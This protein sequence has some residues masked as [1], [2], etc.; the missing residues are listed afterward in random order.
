LAEKKLE[1]YINY[2]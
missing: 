1:V 2:C